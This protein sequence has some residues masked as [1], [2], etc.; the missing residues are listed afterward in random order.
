MTITSIS[1]ALATVDLTAPAAA[2]EKA[3]DRMKL[4]QAVTTVNDSKTFG[5]N[6]ELT[7][8]LDRA[9][10]RTLVRLI[11]RQ[12]QEVVMQIPP[13]YILRLAEEMTQDSAG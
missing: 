6:Q 9:T 12:T 10:H 1:P 13:E 3:A 2:P 4:A 11:D 5:D 8:V 7:F